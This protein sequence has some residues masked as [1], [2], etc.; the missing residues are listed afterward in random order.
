MWRPALK[1]L[2]RATWYCER[3]ADESRWKIYQQIPQFAVYGMTFAIDIEA[4]RER[5][6]I[7]VRGGLPIDGPVCVRGRDYK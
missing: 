6:I 7:R 3:I 4:K 1:F 5:E 2:A